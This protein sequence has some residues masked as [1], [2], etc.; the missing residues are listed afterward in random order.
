VTPV[1]SGLLVGTGKFFKGVIGKQ[2]EEVDLLQEARYVDVGG[3]CV[4][5][6]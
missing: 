5:V 4:R 2:E 1:E 3:M 6:L